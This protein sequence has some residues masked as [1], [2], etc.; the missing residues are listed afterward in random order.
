MSIFRNDLETCESFICVFTHI[1]DWIQH[2]LFTLLIDIYHFKK[3]VSVINGGQW[4]S[5][6][7]NDQRMRNNIY[8][9]S[10]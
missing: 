1:V 6:N 2:T 9:S 5:I 3:H 7:K 4:R 10:G 8:S